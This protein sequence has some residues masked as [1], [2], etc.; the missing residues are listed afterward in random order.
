M[1]DLPK[2]RALDRATV[3]ALI[4]TS[5]SAEVEEEVWNLYRFATDHYLLLSTER[6]PELGSS[7]AIHPIGSGTPRDE[8]VDSTQSF[9]TLKQ[10]SIRIQELVD[11][12]GLKPSVGVAAVGLTEALL[13]ENLIY[14]H[15]STEA[16]RQMARDAVSRIVIR[17]DRG[18]VIVRKWRCGH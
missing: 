16:R 11:D 9:L 15:S 7:I 17:V 18:T 3:A 4:E 5:W 1:Q 14:N 2:V 8:V 13:Q 6:I 10:A 12:Q